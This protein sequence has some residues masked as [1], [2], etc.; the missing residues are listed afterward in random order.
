MPR[1]AATSATIDAL[2]ARIQLLDSA[3]SAADAGPSARPDAQRMWSQRVQLMNSLVG[4]RYAEAVRVGYQTTSHE[5][6]M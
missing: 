4:M 2:Q 5:G 3:L 6:D 1:A